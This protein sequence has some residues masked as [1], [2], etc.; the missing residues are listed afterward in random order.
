M[1]Q[2]HEANSEAHSKLKKEN[3]T[4]KEKICNLEKDNS[5]LK[6]KSKE[7]EKE[8]LSEAPLDSESII[9]KHGI[10]FQ[11][12]LARNIDISK[13]TSM[14][15]GVSK[16][17]KICLGYVPPKNS[18]VKPNSKQKANKASPIYSHL[19]YGH[20]HDD[21][22][23]K[24]WV[25]K[26]SGRTNKKGPKKI[27]APKDKIIYV[28]DILSNQ[29]ETPILVLDSG[30]LRHM[31]GR[32]HMFQSLELKPEG[33]VGFRGNQKG[34]IVGSGTIGNDSVPSINNVLLFKRLMHNLLSI[35]QLS[36][37]GYDIIFNQQSCKAVSQ[38]DGFLLFNGKRK[39]N[40][41]KIRLFDLEN[42]NVKYLMPVN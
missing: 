17:G 5:A 14:I 41:Y 37:N 32:R 16:N 38:K 9:K 15:S 31:S 27:W 35:I 22:A 3:S 26:S 2:V 19:T 21:S 18:R 13:T 11:T 24:P 4:L 23:Q 10:S 42:Q 12:F 7:L 30:C 20:T 36:D 34:K 6:S 29:V 1:K 28:E 40:I 8:I 39:N 33:N 25:K